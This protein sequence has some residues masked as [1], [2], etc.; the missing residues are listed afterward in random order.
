[1]GEGVERGVEVCFGAKQ[2][3]TLR[4]RIQ[5]AKYLP[6]ISSSTSLHS[7][8]HQSTFKIPPACILPHPIQLTLAPTKHTLYG[9]EN[10]SLMLNCERILLDKLRII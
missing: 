10:H 4:I 9:K 3:F 5:A 6:S 8:Q 1:M 7:H 2:R